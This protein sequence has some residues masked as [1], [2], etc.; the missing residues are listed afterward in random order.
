MG[1]LPD[2]V[3]G[4]LARVLGAYLR[5]KP[6]AE[7]PPRL[8]PYQH[9][10]PKSL[11]ARRA[12]LVQALETEGFRAQVK[13][14]LDDKPALSKEEK[15][16]L[17]IAVEREGGWKEKLGEGTKP[18]PKPKTKRAA[19]KSKPDLKAQLD[20]ERQRSR[21]TREETRRLRSESQ[22]SL[23][24]STTK[25]DQLTKEVASL[26]SELRAAQKEAKAYKDAAAKAELALERDRRKNKSE[27]EK[28]RS[29]AERA[30]K[31]L[32]E[33]RRELQQ[34]VRRIRNLDEKVAALT[35]P[36]AAPTARKAPKGPR[37]KLPVPKGRLEDAPETLDNW[38][39]TSDVHL[40]IDGYNATMAEGGFGNLGLEGQ[41]DRLVDTVAKLARRKGI[42]ATVIFDGS[43]VVSAPRRNKGVTV[44]YTREDEIADDRLISMLE[45]MPPYPVV[46][47]T[48]DR[49]LQGRARALGATVATSH[50]L[51]ALL[52]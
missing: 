7:L 20:A 41:R 34:K 27:L 30:R 49:E 43:D 36:K 3:A 25:I 45:R 38:L 32:K 6:A 48:N 50:Q 46:V 22:S 18:K 8:R 19:T 52:R 35:A 39:E 16:L 47:A 33:A 5:S 24:E 11:V 26:R 23:K 9:F 21:K 31:D 15:A 51:L 17:R 28:H 2:D 29:S 14:W 4:A 40:L 10:R 12:E 13:E 37:R 42:R 44:Q 1:A